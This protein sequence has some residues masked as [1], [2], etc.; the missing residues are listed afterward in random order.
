[1]QTLMQKHLMQ[2]R[3]YYHLLVGT[4]RSVLMVKKLPIRVIALKSKLA[5]V[6]S[7]IAEKKAKLNGVEYSVAASS[8]NIDT[9]G[10]ILR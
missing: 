5:G 3:R 2:Q 7:A 4:F 8:I 1:M 9:S 6:I 10:F